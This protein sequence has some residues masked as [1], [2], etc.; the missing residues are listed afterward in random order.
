MFRFQVELADVGRGVY[1]S[2]DLRVAQHPSE[3]DRYT[4]ARVLAYALQY[5]EGIE[6]S[7]GL[8]NADEPAIWIK[9]LRGEVRAWIDIGQPSAERLHRAS[10][11]GARVVV[12]AHRD[13]APLLRELARATV[14]R[15]DELEIWELPSALLD[16]LERALERQ[17]RWSLTVSE[18]ALYVTRNGQTHEGSVLRHPLEA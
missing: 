6:L 1:E 17:E 7:R 15:R 18:G 2:L 5:E 12:Y 3:N 11:L 16:A 14:H 4:L 13:P 9:D 8:S 10:K